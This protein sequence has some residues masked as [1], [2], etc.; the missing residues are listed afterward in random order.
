MSLNEDN[1]INKNLKIA[2][3]GSVKT[4]K[5]TYLMKI[6]GHKIDKDLKYN[7]SIGGAYTYSEIVFKKN[8]FHLDFWELSGHE[9]FYSINKIFIRKSDIIFIFYNSYDISSFEIAKRLVKTCKEN[10]KKNTMFV[11]IRSRYDE[12]LETNDN[13]NIVSDEEALEYADLN[14]LYFTH[15]SNFEKND[16]GFDELLKIALK[17]FIN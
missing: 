3:L 13:K 8:N 5:S 1:T 16:I 2:L 7:P 17:N 11:L 9:R 4:G 15:F 6:R 10:S 14:N 12:C